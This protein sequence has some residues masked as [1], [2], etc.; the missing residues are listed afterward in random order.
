MTGCSDSNRQR[1]KGEGGRRWED[2]NRGGVKGWVL[3]SK[4]GGGGGRVGGVGWRWQGGGGGV[5]RGGGCVG[6]QGL[7]GGVRGGGV[8]PN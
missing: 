1:R 3:E 8:V 5:K 4:G 6:E 7:G 2:E